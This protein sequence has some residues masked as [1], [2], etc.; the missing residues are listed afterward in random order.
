MVNLSG[1]IIRGLNN[2][3]THTHTHTHTHI[4]T[5]SLWPTA[6]DCDDLPA[7]DNGKLIFSAGT[8]FGSIVTYS[9]NPGYKLV[10]L[11]TRTCLEDKTWT[12]TAPTCESE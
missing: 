2:D 9:C 3:S 8:T 11:E 12:G 6:V 5:L 10:G 1:L 4:H 7:P